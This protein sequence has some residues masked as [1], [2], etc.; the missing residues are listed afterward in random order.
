MSR[1][2]PTRRAVNRRQPQPARS[3]TTIYAFRSPSPR[4]RSD[5]TLTDSCSSRITSSPRVQG[6]RRRNGSSL[7]R[8]NA[9][10]IR[11]RLAG[12]WGL[13]SGYD[14]PFG[15]CPARWERSVRC[16]GSEGR[17]PPSR[18]GTAPLSANLGPSIVRRSPARTWLSGRAR[19]RVVG[20]LPATQG[21]GPWTNPQRTQLRWG[22]RVALCLHTMRCAT[23]VCSDRFRGAPSGYARCVLHLIAR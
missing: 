23:L 12:V 3:T 9:P 20:P 7:G 21:P 18:T 6:V 17:G 19:T 4:M 10:G 13:E 11:Q 5:Q 1:A 2:W 22:F 16:P 15:L 8:R 14:L